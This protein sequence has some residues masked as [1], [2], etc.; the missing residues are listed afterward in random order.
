[1]L[2]M[3]LFVAKIFRRRFV[4]VSVMR[5]N[6]PGASASPA[7][8]IFSPYTDTRQRHRC[9]LDFGKTTCNES[10]LY[11]LNNQ[12]VL[13]AAHSLNALSRQFVIIRIRSILPPSNGPSMRSGQHSI[14]S[15]FS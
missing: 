11:L 1:M 3:H 9:A 10:A 6:A 5:S 2:D 12:W 13:C 4:L 8:I 7:I 15:N 14:R